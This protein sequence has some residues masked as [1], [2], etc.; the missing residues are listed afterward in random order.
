MPPHQVTITPSDHSFVCNEGDT[1]LAAA[2]AADLMLPYGCRNGACGTCKG[3]IVEGRVDYG[4]HQASTLTEA[5][6]RLG[7][8]L[9]CCANRCR[10]S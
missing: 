9:F 7:L 4:P 8:A 3:K 5:E 1:V 10:I 6:K 2:M